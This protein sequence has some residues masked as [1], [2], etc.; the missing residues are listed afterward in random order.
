MG[1][2]YSKN[3]STRKYSRVSEYLVLEYSLAIFFFIFN[4]LS[5]RE[6]SKRV[7]LEASRH[8]MIIYYFFLGTGS[9]RM[10]PIQPTKTAT[11]GKSRVCRLFIVC[12]R[13]QTSCRRHQT[14]FLQSTPPSVPCVRLSA[15]LCFERL[16]ISDLYISHLHLFKSRSATAAFTGPTLNWILFCYVSLVSQPVC[17]TEYY[18]P[19]E[20]RELTL[21]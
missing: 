4:Y 11:L 1:N 14:S 21:T 10:S 2:E 17:W 8:Y 6:Y 7:L 9:L 5:T 16:T 15:C 12:R 13:C 19:S 3:A 18:W 20:L